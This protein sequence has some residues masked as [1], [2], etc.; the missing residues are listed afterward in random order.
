[1]PHQQD[2]FNVVN[3]NLPIQLFQHCHF[4]KFVVVGKHFH[5]HN[6]SSH[7]FNV[8][9]VYL[10]NEQHCLWINK[11]VI[12][13]HDKF[14]SSNSGRAAEARSANRINTGR[15]FRP[16]A[17]LRSP[18]LVQTQFAPSY[19]LPAATHPLYFFLQARI[20]ISSHNPLIIS[21]KISIVIT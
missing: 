8:I 19:V 20:I 10:H 15:L 17:C 2:R 12:K 14:A 18:L 9:G 1:M 3:Y 16:S 11:Y 13:H 4:L 21:I 7:I 5:L 6:M